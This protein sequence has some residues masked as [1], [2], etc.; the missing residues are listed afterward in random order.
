MLDENVYDTF[1]S[2][3]TQTPTC[4][5][6]KQRVTW[7]PVRDDRANAVYVVRFARADCAS[8]ASREHCTR[9]V[10]SRQLTRDTQERYMVLAR[11][12]VR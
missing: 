10:S 2:T 9:S 11:A 3:A 4:P 8:C 6:G 7:V 5:R 12:R 1:R